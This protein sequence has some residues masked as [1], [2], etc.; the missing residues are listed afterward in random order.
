MHCSGFDLCSPRGTTKGHLYEETLQRAPQQKH[1]APLQFLLVL[2]VNLRPEYLN[3]ETKRITFESSWPL[4]CREDHKVLTA[5]Q[6]VLHRRDLR[7]YYQ[8][9]T[10]PELLHQL[11]CISPLLLHLSKRSMTKR[12]NTIMAKVF[13]SKHTWVCLI[14]SMFLKLTFHL[15]ADNVL[16]THTI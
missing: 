7:W 15:H 13:G 2:W 11:G 10:R 12:Y 8:M 9:K 6:T 16:F 3:T 5:P 4:L 14:L 1:R